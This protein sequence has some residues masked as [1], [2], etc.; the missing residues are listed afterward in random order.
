VRLLL[1]LI[2][3]LFFSAPLFAQTAALRG[4]VTDES[5]AVVP[6]ATVT[7]TGAVGTPQTATAADNGSYG[8]AGIVPG[9]YTLQASAPDLSSEALKVELKPGIQ[10]VNVQM[11]V[12]SVAQQLTVEDRAVS[13]TPEPANNAS[14]TVL[15][16]D[17]LE[18]LSDNPDDLIAELIAIAGPSA[19][20]GGASIFIDGFSNG[21]PL[22]KESI[23]EIRINQN[24]FSA[25]YDRLG[26]GR[27]E[28][29]TRPGTNQFHGSGRFNIANDFWNSRNPYAR[30]KAP[31]FLKEYIGNLSGPMGKRASFFVD[32]R[33]DAVDNGAIINGTTLD[34]ATLG[35]I[36]PF[37]D[38]FRIPQRRWGIG[39]RADL[40][41]SSNNTLTLRYTIGHTDIP[42]FGIGGFNLISAGIRNT[43]STQML[44]ATETAVLG[45]NLVNEIRFQFLRNRNEMT[46][47]TFTTAIQVLGSFNGGG[48]PVGHSLD[49]LD[50]YEFQDYMTVIHG[51]HSWR[52]GARLRQQSDDNISRQNFAG[53]FTFGGGTAVV[54]D[55]N[56]QPVPDSADQP[57]IAPLTSIE[58]YRRTLLFRKLGLPPRQIR[59]LGG[60]ATQ[61]SITAG[62]PALAASQFDIGAFVADDWKVN[63]ALTLSLGLRYETQTNIQDR[64][65]VAPRIGIAWA[66][67]AQSANA[68][69]MTV[70]RAGFGMFYD[71][72]GLSNT[73]LALRNNGI[74]QQQYVMTNPDFFPSIPSLSTLGA[75]QSVRDAVSPILI[76]PRLFQSTAGIERQLP[77]NTTL[78]V[79]YA[80]THGLHILG[81]RTINAQAGEV[82]LMES[83]GLYNQNQLIVNVNSRANKYVSL[84]G[85]YALNGAMSNTDG[86]GTFPANPFSFA[87]EYGPAATDVRHRVSAGGS[88]NTRWNVAF[89]PLVNVASGPPFDITVGHDIYGTTLFNGRP[90]IATNPDKPGVIR[91]VYG[92]LDPNPT[93]DERIL[94]RNYGRGPGNVFIN[95]RITK[96]VKLGAKSPHTLSIAMATENILNHTNPGPIIGNV[97][98]P[99]FGHA[100]QPSGRTGSSGFSEAANNRRL[101]VQTQFTF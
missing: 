49:T 74:R 11:K 14:A 31:F 35:I 59:D 89:S 60:G 41:L 45:E 40:Q 37:T 79:T 77:F 19:G 13:V 97:T 101:E 62:D 42:H 64:H 1:R 58:R 83:S 21:Q 29:L 27:I 81:S 32:L 51:P 92:L 80:N 54:L 47:E 91:T 28:I 93:P 39:P 17:D 68:R 72:F 20:P 10:T 5:G 87:G 33:R 44:Q 55:E 66:P 65:D 56:N 84:T 63:R 78:A 67:G 7:L 57:V 24:P 8:F 52:F 99:L 73:M 9:S 94:H 43:T 50:N 96:T 85:S 75:F 86:V 76:A 95:L 16:G 25:E 18:A 36:D 46:P 26:T 23:R 90:G 71:R 70:L 22:S 34:P 53:T 3:L 15:G 88:I 48:S 12:V 6:G 38:V 100:N 30:Q 98:S 4:V 82:F 61:F 2:L 69:A